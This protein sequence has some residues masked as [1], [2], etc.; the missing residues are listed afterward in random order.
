MHSRKLR[1]HIEALDAHLTAL[2]EQLRSV[3]P[4]EFPD[5]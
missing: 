2:K 5:D 4:V 3:A 1:A